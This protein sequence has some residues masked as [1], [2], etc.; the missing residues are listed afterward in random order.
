MV[1]RIHRLLLAVLVM[2]Y[3][4]PAHAQTTAEPIRYTLSFPA[5]HTH[6]VEVTAVG[7][8]RRTCRRWS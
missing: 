4:A 1:A 2:T 8:D 6:Y 5:P 3:A 7:P